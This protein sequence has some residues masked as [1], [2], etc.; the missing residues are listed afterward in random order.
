[1]ILFPPRNPDWWIEVQDEHGKAL[2]QFYP[3][4]DLGQKVAKALG[5]RGSEIYYLYHLVAD[6]RIFMGF[7][8][9]GKY[10]QKET[11]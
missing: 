11:A 10:K 4:M 7:V 1:M 5:P 9:D 6:K 8:S 3:G 2:L